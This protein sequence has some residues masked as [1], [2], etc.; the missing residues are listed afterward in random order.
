MEI[1]VDQ[2]ALQQVSG[3]SWRIGAE[4]GIGITL[5]AQASFAAE[6]NVS[7]FS[8]RDEL[9]RVERIGTALRIAKGSPILVEAKALVS[10]PW[11]TLLLLLG[12]NRDRKNKEKNN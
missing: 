10:F 4:A 5:V 3:I 7:L 9:Q 8:E 6:G 12:K 2:V 11:R 1:A